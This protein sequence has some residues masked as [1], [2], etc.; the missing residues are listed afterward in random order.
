MLSGS[1]MAR[2][3]VSVSEELAASSLRIEMGSVRRC[4]GHNERWSVGHSISAE[5]VY[6]PVRVSSREQECGRL[7]KKKASGVLS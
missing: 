3:C 4:L 1:C 6:S 5:G 2:N 7:V